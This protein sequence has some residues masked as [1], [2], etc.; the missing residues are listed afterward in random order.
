[1]ISGGAQLVRD[2]V[3]LRLQ[4][5]KLISLDRHLFLFRDGNRTVQ[6]T[7]RFEAGIPRF[8]HRLAGAQTKVGCLRKKPLCHGNAFSSHRLIFSQLALNSTNFAAKP[9]QLGHACDIV[10]VDGPEE[11]GHRVL[12]GLWKPLFALL[13]EEMSIAVDLCL[14]LEAVDQRMGDSGLQWQSCLAGWRVVAILP[15]A[16][17]GREQAFEGIWVCCLHE[18]V[19]AR[20]LDL[21][22]DGIVNIGRRVPPWSRKPPGDECLSGRDYQSNACPGDGAA[23]DAFRDLTLGGTEAVFQ[24][25][26]QRR[27]ARLGGSG[28]D[29]ESAG[30]KLKASHFAIVSIENYVFDLK[31]HGRI[32]QSAMVVSV[33]GVVPNHF[34]R[35]RARDTQS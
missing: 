11:V 18:L 10:I 28:D 2:I 16:C 3:S 25:G 8:R 4:A 35:K 26:Y 31:A 34:P 30:S 22:S 33:E 19:G 27:L 15:N 5:T 6:S 14:M 24:N 32:P 23:H 12:Y 20:Q 9:P 21:V 29:V 7:E 1:L 17:M 13:V